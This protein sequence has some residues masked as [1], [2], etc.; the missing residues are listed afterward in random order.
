M[1]DR[2]PTCLAWILER[3][4]GIPQ[5][6]GGPYVRQRGGYVW[7]DRHGRL[8]GPDGRVRKL[9]TGPDGMAYD[10]D[11]HDTGGRTCMGV[12]QRVYDGYRKRRG[13]LMQDV[14]LI[15]DT[16]ITDIYR[17][18]YWTPIRGDDLPPGIDLSV[19]DM[20]VNAGVRVGVRLLQRAAGMTGAAVD[21]HL[22]ESTLRTVADQDA[23]EL[24]ERYRIERDR[25]Y[26]QIKTFWRF[27]AG[28]LARSEATATEASRHAAGAAGLVTRP[29][30]D[31][32]PTPR[33]APDAPDAAVPT[34]AA[35]AGTGGA[36]TTGVELTRA[37]AAAGKDPSWQDVLLSVAQSPL[38][39]VGLTTVVTAVY[40]WLANR[41]ERWA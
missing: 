36:V 2:F 19:F 30:E 13:L 28:W 18:Q 26:R 37:V 6:P 27:G 9:P 29:P 16:E 23:G 32:T 31:L 8:V 41:R 11:P 39:W 20:G 24:I 33:A 21:G 25:Y 7:D 17:Q 12:I 14:W 40:V 15:A 10:D 35:G 5:R 4:C 38:F 34:A 3:E 1:T 22:G